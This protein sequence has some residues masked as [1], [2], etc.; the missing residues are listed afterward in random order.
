M[1]SFSPCIEQVQKTAEKMRSMGF[2]EIVTLECLLREF[3]VRKITIPVYEPEREASN[4]KQTDV[5]ESCESK[6][7][8]LEEDGE[9]NGVERPAEEAKVAKT[10]A[11]KNFYTGIPLVNMPGHTGYLTFATLAA[12]V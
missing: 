3:Q 4:G 2:N 12:K 9:E 6:K 7:R 5:E 1:C 11:E 8:K 10:K